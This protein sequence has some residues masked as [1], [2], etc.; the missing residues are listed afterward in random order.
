LKILIIGAGL[1]GLTAGCALHQKG[2]TVTV[3][4]KGRGIGGRLAT[5]RLQVGRADHGAQYFSAQT[6]DFQDFTQIWIRSGLVQAW[7]LEQSDPAS[8]QHPRYVV[9]GG[10]KGMAVQ[11]ADD[12]DIRT[13]ERA[14]Y[15]NPT[16]VGWQ[17]RCESGLT[18]AADALLLT[19]PVPQA[20]LLLSDSGIDLA[21]AD[22]QA[23]TQVRYEPCLAVL[24]RLSE[25][26]RLPAP[27]G[28]KRTH[29]PVAWIADNQQKGVSEQPTLTLH[30]SHEYSQKHLDDADLQL[31]IPELLASVADL[32]DPATI[33]EQQIHRWRYSNA[34]MRHPEPFL[35]ANVHGAGTLL[36]GGDG[37]GKGNVEGAFTSG[38]AMA[39]QIVRQVEGK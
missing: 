10:M 21:D 8:F 34:T 7:H 38:L 5:R 13:G 14:T 3:L 17:V 20:L 22:W 30:A 33:V 11:F 29:G 26:S 15:L 28:L 32:V 37:F 31:L 6:S 23:L 9:R 2:Y 36:F 18:L 4:D 27:G 16:G 39:R 1:S 25:P 12:L 19:V 35:A 24:L